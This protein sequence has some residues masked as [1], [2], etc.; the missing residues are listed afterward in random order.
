MSMENNTKYIGNVVVQNQKI[1]IDG[2]F[3]KCNSMM[4]CIDGLPTI[5][6]G[7]QEAKRYIPS[8][9]IL[10]K[11]YNDNMLWWT[12]SKTERRSDHDDDISKFYDFCI[13]NIINNIKYYYIN[14]IELT[15]TET[16]KLINYISN[17]KIKKY[18]YVE[19]N[20]FLFLYDE[21]N[22]NIIYGFS[23]STAAFYGIS[24][25]KIMVKL[26][27]N[28]N[29]IKIKNFYSLPNEIRR[30]V[31]DEIPYKMILLDYFNEK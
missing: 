28:K 19:N 24:K 5:I 4:E 11:T 23:L 10:S 18:Y 27:T 17:E 3:N 6:I 29:N 31:D 12:F 8:F 2:C 1:K 14:I 22:K 16:K 15:Y 13:N 26:E 9:S 20:S 7:L 25:K 21:K 30:K